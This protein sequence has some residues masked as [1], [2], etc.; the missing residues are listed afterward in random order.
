MR[1]S[2]QDDRWN[3]GPRLSVG[4]TAAAAAACGATLYTAGGQDNVR[5]FDC[6]EAL[7][8]ERGWTPLEGRLAVARKYHGMD[9]GPDR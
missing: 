7:D 9:A 5:V 6:C 3:A 4:R 2:S 1:Y 8:R